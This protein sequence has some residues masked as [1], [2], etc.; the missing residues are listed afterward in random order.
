M[1]GEAIGRRIT[2]FDSAA[3]A[4]LGVTLLLGVVVLEI[5]LFGVF[6]TSCLLSCIFSVLID[7][8]ISCFYGSVLTCGFWITACL[9][10][11]N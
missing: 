10:G 2:R 5:V 1:N 3:C 9:T 8:S 6:L 7:R 4:P 11:T